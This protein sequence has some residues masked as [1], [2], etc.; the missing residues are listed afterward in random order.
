MVI[1][2][3]APEPSLGLIDDLLRHE[4]GMITKGEVRAVTLAKLQMVPNAILWDVGASSGSVA[5]EAVR[6]TEG[7]KAYAVEKV[8]KR[9]A[10]LKKN[11]ATYAPGQVVPVA[12]E[13]PEVLRDLPDPD[14]VFVGGGGKNLPAILRTVAT[15]LKKRGRIVVNTV[16]LESL[17]EARAVLAAKK[18]SIEVISLQV[19][20][21]K[22]LSGRTMLKAENPVFIVS[23]E[24]T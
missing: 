17:G 12:G 6:L 14:R 21:G 18:F 13:A 5:I 22:E 7:A 19:S 11:I 8:S 24:I 15:R 9:L 10:L 4:K 20:R 2:N 1:V 3:E 23:G 16:T